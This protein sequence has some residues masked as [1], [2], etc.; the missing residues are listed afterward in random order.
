MSE[1]HFY[2]HTCYKRAVRSTVAELKKRKSSLTLAKLAG[3]IPVQY[4][5]LSKALNDPKAHLN[6]DHLFKLGRLLELLPDEIDFLLLLR[7][8]AT[9]STPDRREYLSAK[10]EALRKERTLSADHVSR[11]G[12]RLRTEM[13][14]L[15]NPMCM[16]VHAAL[17]IREYEKDPRR[18]MNPLG[19]TEERLK[20]V[21]LILEQNEFLELGKTPFQIKEVKSKFPHYGPDH[22]LMR[23][24]QQVVKGALVQKLS[25][26]PESDKESFFVTF[27]MDETAFGE[28]KKR[29]RAFLQ[30]IQ[31]LTF[32]C[33]HKNVYQ[34]NFDL[35]KWF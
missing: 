7:S 9:A 10:I 16:V 19:L 21:L 1:S 24:H 22:P 33:K 3:Q 5:F 30:D 23:L 25:A 20:E 11:T 6:E 4:T 2:S 27:T 35:V 29:F 15:F 8:Q 34:L 13:S 26:I 12:D 32:E 17:F 31:K 18:L 14:Y 28:V